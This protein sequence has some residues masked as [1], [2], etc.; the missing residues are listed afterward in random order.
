MSLM[1]YP[2]RE[3]KLLEFKSIVPKF[4]ALIQTCIAFANAAGGRI[5]IGV[6]DET[7]EIIGVTDE[8]RHRIYDDFP[9]SLYDSASPTLIPQIYEQN[10]GQH[11][12]LI[13]EIPVSPRK[14][15]FL[16]NK[17]MASGT[18]IRVGSSTRKANS[19]Y[20][21][22]LVRES[23]R[24]H[25]DE[26]LVIASIDVLSKDLLQEFYPSKVTKKRMVSD[27]V[28]LPFPA[29]KEHYAPT[30]SGVLMFCKSP[31]DHIPEALIRCTRFKGTTGRD[32]LRTE[33]IVGTIEEQAEECLK[34]IKTWMMTDYVLK[35]SKLVGHMPVPIEAIRESIINALLHRK[36]SI[37]GAIKVAIYD[38]RVEIFS[39]GCFPG[40]V[41]INHLG[42]GMTYQRNP[43]L[44][45]LAYQ[46]NLIE[47]R[48]TGIRLIYDSCKKQGI[49][50]PV[51]HEDGDFVKVVFFLAP[52]RT[53]YDNEE[54]MI[55]TYI[56]QLGQANAQQIAGYLSVSH[57]TA[58]RKLRTL[59][60]EKKV[61][62]IGN[63]RARKY[64]LADD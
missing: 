63:A 57:N 44:A 43:T 33:D 23:Q 45:K 61:K 20:I 19:E 10:F 49:Q 28:I 9:N 41:D 39:P 4:S 24:I 2:E 48:G 14:P 56:R 54:E 26:E 34:V 32:I 59:I 38:D 25:Y 51:F 36:Y 18:Y 17:G 64:L 55:I 50:K 60:N 47:S 31:H 16:K 6:D 21:E 29:N 42:D 13:V 3:S 40:L 37:P 12:V 7:R 52:D 30:V 8:D 1:A 35:G 46:S 62:A 53:Q 15:Y 5:I 22:D 11:S 58:L 27:K